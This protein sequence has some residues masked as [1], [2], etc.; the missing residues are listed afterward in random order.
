MSTC[1]HVC[2]CSHMYL[3]TL[4]I[5]LIIVHI[6]HI[7]N[8]IKFLHPHSTLCTSHTVT[9]NT[10]PRIYALCPIDYIQTSNE[11]PLCLGWATPTIA[12]E[13]FKTH[14]HAFH[15][16]LNHTY[17]YML[18][19]LRSTTCIDFCGDHLEILWI[20]LHS[21]EQYHSIIN[22]YRRLRRNL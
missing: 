13:A 22:C 10:L 8:N 3:L 9:N 15:V 11:H 5:T 2:M 16:W 18:S 14:S 21:W 6:T 4:T 20:Y 19:L 12:I 17:T 7:Y 1:T